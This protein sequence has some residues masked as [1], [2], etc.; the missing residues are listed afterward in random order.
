MGGGNYLTRTARPGDT[1]YRF[2]YKGIRVRDL[3]ASLRFYTKV[4]GV[5]EHRRG[6]MGHGGTYVALRS[7]G[8]SQELE[9]N[10]Y[11]DG[12][13]F[14]TEY[15]NR[16]ELDHLA[17]VVDDVEAAFRDLVKK[18]AGLAIDPAH[19]KG[20]EIYVKDPSGIWI[21]LLE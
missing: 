2:R 13:R 18:G 20:T 10:Y 7:P 16:E 6:T 11:P 4:L 8:S 19:A 1:K 12:S 3:E 21:E 5:K 17:F 14:A 15:R 9:L